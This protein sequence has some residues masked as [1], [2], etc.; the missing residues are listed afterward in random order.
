MTISWDT[1]DLRSKLAKVPQESM[2]QLTSETDKYAL[3]AQNHARTNAPWTDRT[4]NAR[5][6]LFA[7]PFSDNKSFEIV[8]YHTMP[9]GIWLE[10]RWGGRYSIIP[11]TVTRVSRVY[12]AAM[13]AKLADILRGV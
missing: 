13:T 1:A 2:R 6:G 10:R 5:Q 12:T 3:V 11:D 8:L 9:Y 4:G 7:Q